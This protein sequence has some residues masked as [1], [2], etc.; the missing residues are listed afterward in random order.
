MREVET[1]EDMYSIFGEGKEVSEEDF[2]VD[3]C[4]PEIDFENSIGI[5]ENKFSNQVANYFGETFTY[6]KQPL[7]KEYCKRVSKCLAMSIAEYFSNGEIKSKE[8]CRDKSGEMSRSY[9][10][11]IEFFS[12]NKIL[13]SDKWELIGFEAYE[14]VRRFIQKLNPYQRYII[15]YE[16]CSAEIS[17]NFFEELDISAKVCSIL[18][19]NPWM[20]KLSKDVPEFGKELEIVFG[21]NDLKILHLTIVRSH[22]GHLLL[23]EYKDLSNSM[24][25]ILEVIDCNPNGYYKS[26]PMRENSQIIVL[27]ILSKLLGGKY[28]IQNK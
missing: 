13:D 15:G 24:R 5:N 18:K 25:A 19:D 23:N 28:N 4:I 27:T 6:G 8:F 26:L 10:N 17:R 2:V 3:L 12:N 20:E 22:F 7:N 14:V 9:D 21:G 11:L 1:Y 16:N